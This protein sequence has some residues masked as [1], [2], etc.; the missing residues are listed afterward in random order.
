MPSIDEIAAK[1]GATSGDKFDALATKYGSSAAQ[2]AAKPSL[3]DQV[4]KTGGD[5]AEGAVRATGNKFAGLVRGAGSIGTTLLAPVDMAMD[6]YYGDR[7]RNLSSLV[8]GKELPTRNQERRQGMDEG[9]K[10]LANFKLEAGI[11]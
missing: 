2:V 4:L 3:M 6:A 5:I 7:G 1:Y 10:A 11:K 9:L 8:T